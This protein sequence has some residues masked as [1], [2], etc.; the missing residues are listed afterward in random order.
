MLDGDM[1][2]DGDMCVDGDMFIDAPEWRKIT[3]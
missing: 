2:I 3:T 1:C